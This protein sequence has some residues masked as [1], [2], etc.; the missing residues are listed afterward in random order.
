VDPTGTVGNVISKRFLTTC[1]S[2][3][4]APVASTEVTGASDAKEVK[5]LPNT[6]VVTNAKEINL[7]NLFIIA[8]LLELVFSYIFFVLLIFYETII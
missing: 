2:L 1:P 6:I 8:L 3:E 7:P 5:E 4:P